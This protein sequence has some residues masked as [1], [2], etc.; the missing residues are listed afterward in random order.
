MGLSAAPFRHIFCPTVLFPINLG[1]DNSTKWHLA[2]VL[3]MLLLQ[4]KGL[5]QWLGLYCLYDCASL[6]CPHVEN[7]HIC[8]FAHWQFSVCLI[9]Q[10]KKTTFNDLI[11]IYCMSIS[12]RSQHCC[13]RILDSKWEGNLTKPVLPTFSQENVHDHSHSFSFPLKLKSSLFRFLQIFTDQPFSTM[14][15]RNMTL[16]A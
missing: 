6:L 5:L 16:A 8:V 2:S 15:V 11:F 12:D 10:T 13:H 7:F 3:K 14:C 9:L 4:H 1:S